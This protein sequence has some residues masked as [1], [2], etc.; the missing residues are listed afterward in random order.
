MHGLD[1]SS[2]SKADIE[3]GDFVIIFLMFSEDLEVSTAGFRKLASYIPLGLTQINRTTGVLAKGFLLRAPLLEKLIPLYK[4]LIN[5]NSPIE[6][7][8][9][10]VVETLS[11]LAFVPPVLKDQCW[12][13]KYYR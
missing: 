7:L 6:T 13:E 11:T 1:V 8:V 3:L 4:G 10:K 5:S 9:L 12:E 2:N